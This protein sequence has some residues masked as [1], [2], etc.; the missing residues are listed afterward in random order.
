MI[1]AL[2]TLPAHPQSVP[3]NALVAVAGTPAAK[4]E[5]LESAETSCALIAVAAAHHHAGIVVV[6]LSAGAGGDERRNP[7]PVF[8]GRGHLIFYGEKLLTTPNPETLRPTRPCF[9][10]SAC[11]PWGQ[12]SLPSL[13]RVS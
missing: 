3:I 9:P 11:G 8:A 6:R 13:T 4:P 12:H 2:A 7:G 5:K 1:H 10:G